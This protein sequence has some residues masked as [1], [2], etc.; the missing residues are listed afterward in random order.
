MHHYSLKPF[1]SASG[2]TSS[3][4]CLSASMFQ[5]S[6]SYPS[7]LNASFLAPMPI[8]LGA[9]FGCQISLSSWFQNL[10]P[11]H[12]L[13]LALDIVIICLFTLYFCKP[14][15]KCGCGKSKLHL[16]SGLIDHLFLDGLNDAIH[17]S[18]LPMNNKAINSP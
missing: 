10:Q 15:F 17:P 4:L 13:L 1:A 3:P 6:S 9:S 18:S 14:G 2:K 5:S 7:H 8:L 12:L 11:L 16:V